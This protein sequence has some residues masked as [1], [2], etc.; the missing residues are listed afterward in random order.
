VTDGDSRFDLTVG[1]KSWFFYPIERLG[2]VC[3]HRDTSRGWMSR[4]GLRPGKI[5]WEVQEAYQPGVVREKLTRGPLEYAALWQVA[6]RM[7]DRPVKFGA[8]C[9]PALAS[10]LWNEYYDDDKAMVFEL[11]EIMNAERP[12]M[13][14]RHFLSA[15]AACLGCVS[16]GIAQAQT[17]PTRP[18]TMIVPIGAGSISDV[19]GRIVVERMRVSLGQPIIIENVSGADGT[20]GTGRAARARPDGY[21]ID[22]GTTSHVLNAAFYSLPYDVLN[23]FTPIAPLVTNPVV[24]FARRTMPA[25]N[26]N[27]L[28]TWLKANPNKASAGI[29]TVGFRLLNVFFQNETGTQFTLV[30]YRGTPAVMQ[31]LLA[32]Q[33]DLWF[34]STDQLPLIRASSIKAYA[35]TSDTRSTFAPDIPTFAEMG[36]PALSYSVWVGIFAP[37]GTPKNIIDKLN[38]AAV[39]ALADP[40]VRQRLADLGSE[41]FP[42]EQQTAE[43]LA[44]IVKAGAEKWWPII[45]ASG[46]KA[47]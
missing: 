40:A 8:I 9:A 24:L 45:K 18:I 27:E 5:L 23:D 19:A 7:T 25:M 16:A 29:T 26:L 17:Y 43:A 41:V 22:L 38:A 33:I 39:D 31:D 10:M 6:Q 37:K 15:S 11:C 35:V 32:G 1:G 20:I 44:A 12:M 47:E 13:T 21:T 28:I 42:R 30:P 2:G 4:H 3:G 34:G 14:R 36:L 46:I